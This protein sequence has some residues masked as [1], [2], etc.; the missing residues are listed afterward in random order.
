MY[1]LSNISKFQGS[2]I[3]PSGKVIQLIAVTLKLK[4]RSPEA[5]F[6]TFSSN[7]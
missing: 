5:Q 1:I 3:S 7:L 6:S 2:A 4:P